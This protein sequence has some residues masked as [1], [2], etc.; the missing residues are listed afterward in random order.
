MARSNERRYWMINVGPFD[1]DEAV[2]W[3]EGVRRTFTVD[4]L[5]IHLFRD[6]EWFSGAF[7]AATIRPAIAALKIALKGH[8]LD[9][10]DRQIVEGVLSDMQTWLE[11]DYDSSVDE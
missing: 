3:A 10:D 11:R 4:D 1:E 6:N 5:W 9:D 7:D 8:E 2:Q